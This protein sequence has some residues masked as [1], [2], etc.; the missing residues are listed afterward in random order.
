LTVSLTNASGRCQVFVLAH[1]T[2]CKARG[3]CACDVEQ[4][5]RPKRTA[6]SLTL[7]T[8]VTS[9]IEDAVLAVPE[10]YRAAKR[11]DLVVKRLVSNPARPVVAPTPTVTVAAEVIRPGT[12]AKR[13]RRGAS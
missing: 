13:K 5:R 11:G 2:Y 1:A 10:V 7:A 9:D 4:G 12:K 8:G 6:R 3:E